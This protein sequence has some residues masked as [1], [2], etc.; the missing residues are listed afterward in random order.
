MNRWSAGQ[1]CDVAEVMAVYGYTDPVI[2]PTPK[3][4]TCTVRIEPN[5]A[6][7]EYP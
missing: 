2:N 3:A 4:Q 1:Y 5:R 7:C 6:N